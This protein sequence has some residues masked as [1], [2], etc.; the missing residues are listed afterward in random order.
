VRIV[1]TPKA[2]GHLGRGRRV[3]MDLATFD[4]E[5]DVARF[6]VRDEPMARRE[7]QAWGGVFEY[8][9]AGEIVGVEVRFASA[10][11]PVD[12]LRAL[13]VA[14]SDLQPPGSIGDRASD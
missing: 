8:G 11:L 10:M 13:P 1:P 14:G 3:P 2:M 6:T 7:E 12:L 5:A 4:A 9:R